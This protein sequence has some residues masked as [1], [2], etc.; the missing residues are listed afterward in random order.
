MIKNIL[1]IFV[2]I[3]LN[4]SF[5]C[6]RKESIS[7]GS[8]LSSLDF[9]TNDTLLYVKIPDI[10]FEKLLIGYKI[11][12][13]LDGKL[14]KKNAEKI[15]ELEFNFA[16]IISYQGIEAFK[17]LEKLTFNSCRP[18]NQN[19]DLDISKNFKLASLY[20]YNSAIKAVNINKNT[21]LR[22]LFYDSS[23]LISLDI[24]KNTAL[25]Y[26]HISTIGG[27]VLISNLDL[28]KNTMLKKL[29]CTATQIKKLDISHNTL[30]TKLDCSY[31]SQLTSLDVSKCLSKDFELVCIR[32]N[33]KT[34]CV[35]SLTQPKANWQIDLE[36]EYKV[37][38]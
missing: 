18:Y 30:L 26:L 16:E 14:L 4:I 37:C 9:M 10:N 22:D 1:L 36:T 6:N 13:S 33:I 5:S 7:I 20:I 11:D 12:D 25:E 24:S 38:K 8:S 23:P 27:R 31:N 21:A 2:F 15:T 32:N 28:S 34:I 19:I 3:G 29:T 35:N 17:N